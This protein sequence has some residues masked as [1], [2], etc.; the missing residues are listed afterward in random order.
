MLAWEGAVELKRFL[1]DDFLVAAVLAG[2]F[3]SDTTPSTGKEFLEEYKKDRVILS[4]DD[5]VVIVGKE[6]ARVLL[7]VEQHTIV[8][9]RL[10]NDPKRF[11]LLTQNGYCRFS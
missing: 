4:C 8:T 3:V 2:F 1:S 10:H 6:K 9:I 11:I 5:I 7:H